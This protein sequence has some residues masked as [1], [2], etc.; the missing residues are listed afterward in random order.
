MAFD[1]ISIADAIARVDEAVIIA[2]P[3]MPKDKM[4]ENLIYFST[5]DESFSAIAFQDRTLLGC[6][7]VVL[8]RNDAQARIFSRL[9]FDHNSCFLSQIDAVSR[10]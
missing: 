8:Y 4:L 10:S 7:P 2:I 3:R 5:S 9:F 6:D 1:V